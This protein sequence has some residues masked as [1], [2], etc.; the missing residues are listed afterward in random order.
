MQR[1]AF[2]VRNKDSPLCYLRDAAS[3]VVLDVVV[4]CDFTGLT[5]SLR[6]SVKSTVPFQPNMKPLLVSENLCQ[7]K[8]PISFPY[9]LEELS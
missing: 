8:K 9:I 2:F 5:A 1:Y 6:V 4:Y 7:H 3:V